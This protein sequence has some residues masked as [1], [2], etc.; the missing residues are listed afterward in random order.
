VCL[1]LPRKARQG[2][3]MRMQPCLEIELPSSDA[4]CGLGLLRTEIVALAARASTHAGRL[5]HLSSSIMRMAAR[6]S[7]ST[8][9]ASRPEG[10]CQ[11]PSPP[12]DVGIGPRCYAS[13]HVC[14]SALSR[15][16]ASVEARMGFKT[17]RGPEDVW[18]LLRP[19]TD[20]S[21][22]PSIITSLALSETPYTLQSSQ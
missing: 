3:P 18:L 7:L 12:V 1:C 14:H 11:G 15:T 9:L 13:M 2:M 22:R 16:E 4:E 21:S 17:L 10:S 20:S 8:R 19:A 6:P 5:A